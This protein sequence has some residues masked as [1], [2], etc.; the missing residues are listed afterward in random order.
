GDEAGAQAA[1]S[2]F[3]TA[4][5]LDERPP[6]SPED[7]AEVE[8][9]VARDLAKRDPEALVPVL[10]LFERLYHEAL[11]RRAYLLSTHD[12][13]VV[14]ALTALYVKQSRT[15]TAPAVSPVSAT[16]EL[17]AGFLVGL[18]R[19]RLARGVNSF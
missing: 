1:V 6:V 5:L 3:E 17:A 16:R 10:L 18:A 13:E 14:L 4:H 11:G 19:G 7:L 2:A 12:G 8:G 15:P 9:K